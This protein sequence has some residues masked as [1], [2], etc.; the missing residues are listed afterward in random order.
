MARPYIPEPS[1]ETQAR[2]ILKRIAEFLGCKVTIEF[3]YRDGTHHT[4]IFDHRDDPVGGR[5]NA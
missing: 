3:R 5:V 2:S 1:L 4:A